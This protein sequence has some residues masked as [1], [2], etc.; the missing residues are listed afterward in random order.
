M[1]RFIDEKG[2]LWGRLSVIDLLIIVAV[3]GLGAGFLYKRTSPEITQL[4]RADQKFYVTMSANQL[5]SF[6]VDALAEGDIMFRQHDRRP[7]G[8]VVKLE[9]LPATEFL[10]RSDGT[11]IL[12]EMEDRYKALITVECFGNINE[13]G[14]YVNG[15]MHIAEGSEMVLVSNRVIL[16]DSLVYRVSEH[17]N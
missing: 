16:P 11:A 15:S 6:S 12:A 4:I 5:R 8:Q 13:V 1:K 10:L 14:F 7:M 2:R 3:I 17:L 9:I